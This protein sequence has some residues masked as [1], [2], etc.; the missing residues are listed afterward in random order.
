MLKIRLM[1]TEK[2]IRWFRKILMNL[3]GIEVIGVSEIFSIRT[4]P[5]YFRAY[6]DIESP[7]ETAESANR[8]VNR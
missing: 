4:S 5:R 2:D 8:K 1:G 7:K 6:M 3:P